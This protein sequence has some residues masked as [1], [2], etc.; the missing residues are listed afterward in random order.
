MGGLETEAGKILVGTMQWLR[1]HR[2]CP[3]CSFMLKRINESEF[4][5]ADDTAQCFARLGA[6]SQWFS[7]MVGTRDN[8]GLQSLG[9]ISERVRLVGGTTCQNGEL[10]RIIDP[11]EP[12]FARLRKW[13]QLCESLHSET[14]PIPDKL[15]VESTGRPKNLRVVDLVDNRLTDVE[16]DEKYAALSY[17]W[18]SS[19]SPKLNS[20]ELQRFSVPGFPTCIAAPTAYNDPRYH[21]AHQGTRS[22]VPVVRLVLPHS[23]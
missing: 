14:C 17:V 21:D 3:M 23:R 7:A 12:V 19:N 18:G 15:Q 20:S 5:D 4:A 10:G 9:T 8:P 1:N 22:P 6:S 13:L 16:W 2:H 11:H